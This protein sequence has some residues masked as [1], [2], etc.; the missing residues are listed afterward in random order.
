MR[1]LHKKSAGNSIKNTKK[2]VTMDNYILSINMAMTLD[3]KVARPDG[4]WYGISSQADK[5]QMDAIRSQHEILIVGK[6]SIIND[7]PVL[8]IRYTPS[9]KSIRPVLIVRNGEIPLNRKIFNMKANELPIII[10]SDE[11]FEYFS[12]SLGTRAEIIRLQKN[13]IDPVNVLDKIMGLGYKTI[14][15]EGGPTLNYSFFQSE[16]VNR[17]YLTIVPFLFGKKSLPT[18]VNGEIEFLNFD[19]KKWE[20][21][22]VNKVANEVFLVYNKLR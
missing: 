7:D 10:C 18:I 17:I 8:S 19:Q 15:L 22:E 13:L 14:L 5:I 20:L 9:E 1:F 16:L 6:N 3:G 21:I 11:N 4:R 2:E 12:K